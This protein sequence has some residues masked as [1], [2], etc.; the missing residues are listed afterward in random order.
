MAR[1][2]SDYI[3]AARSVIVLLTVAACFFLLMFPLQFCYA[4]ACRAGLQLPL[5]VIISQ[6]LA[7][8]PP[9]IEGGVAAFLGA[10]LAPV[11]TK[12]YEVDMLASYQQQLGG[13][14]TSTASIAG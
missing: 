5:S 9:Y 8:P 6:K 12:T 11:L 10:T 4:A 3:D 2:R 14:G 13:G 7:M 1:K